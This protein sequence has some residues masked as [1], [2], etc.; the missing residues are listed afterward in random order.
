MWGAVIVMVLE[1]SVEGWLEGSRGG[2][3]LVHH[4]LGDDL[5]D[6]GTPLSGTQLP[7]LGCRRRL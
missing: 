5:G 4:Q 7:A 3:V 1:D 6:R 2:R